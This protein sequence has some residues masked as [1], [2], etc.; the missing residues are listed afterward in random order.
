MTGNPPSYPDD[1]ETV[2]ATLASI[3]G[4]QGRAREGTPES[5]SSP[6]MNVILRM[7]FVDPDSTITPIPNFDLAI[8]A[9]RGDTTRVRTNTLGVATFAVPAGRYRAVPTQ[10]AEFDG[11]RYG[12]DVAFTVR[13]GMGPVDLT[14][15]NAR[16][17]PIPR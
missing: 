7:R 6:R 2:V 12:W 5:T 3:F 8:I 15:R 1:P 17:L 9:E 13:M 10:R 4:A 16:V 11:R 14:Q